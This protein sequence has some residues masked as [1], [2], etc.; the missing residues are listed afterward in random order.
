MRR[1]LRI[2]RVFLALLA[3]LFVLTSLTD[4]LAYSADAQTPVTRAQYGKLVQVFK[5]VVRKVQSLDQRVTALEKRMDE[6]GTPA[7]V[8]SKNESG[9]VD[10]SSLNSGSSSASSAPTV[11]MPLLKT[12]FDLNLMG[13]SQVAPL[14]FQSIHHFLFFELSPSPELQFNFHISDNPYFYELDYLLTKRLKLRFGRIYIPFDDMTPHNIF[15]GRTNV[16]TFALNT[17]TDAAF[18]PTLWTEL[19]VGLRYIFKDT[20]KLFIEG[21]LQFTNGF[22]GGGTDPAATPVATVSASYPNIRFTNDS[23][24]AID[25]NDDKAISGRIAA[26]INNRVGLGAS[27]Y[28]AAFTDRSVEVSQRITGYGVDAQVFWSRVTLRS[29]LAVFNVT[30][31]APSKAFSRSGAY[32]ELSYKLDRAKKWTLQGRGG[33]VQLDD[34]VIDVTDQRIVG[35]RI[36][37]KPGLIEFGLEHSR[38]LQKV[39]GKSNTFVTNLRA[40]AAF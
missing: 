11:A 27:F 24:R 35:G 40:V 33:V 7:S 28:T 2:P 37:F 32:G 26:R 1:T 8:P 36:L 38:D 9:M 18:L 39:D 19:G 3:V 22:Q 30:Q 4:R 15:G 16:G 14:T 23:I 21:A 17:N 29:G 25:N 31:P 20:P 12:Y 5:K 10:L 6:G 13:R 34:R